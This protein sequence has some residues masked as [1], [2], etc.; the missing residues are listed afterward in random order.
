MTQTQ[1]YIL[2]EHLDDLSKD[3]G[4]IK[5]VK[6]VMHALSIRMNNGQAYWLHLDKQSEVCMDELG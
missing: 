2:I 1:V 5:E 6:K 4:G 3:Q